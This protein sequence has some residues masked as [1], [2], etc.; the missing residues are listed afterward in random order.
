M[1]WGSSVKAAKF[2]KRGF[3]KSLESVSKHGGSGCGSIVLL[4][5]TGKYFVKA[6][7]YKQGFPDVSSQSVKQECPTRV[8]SESVK[9][10]CP[11]KCQAGV[12][13]QECPA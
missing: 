11:R 13:F 5:C 12:F 3:Y 1:I 2:H 10:E 8:P 6:L 7:Q 4:S 9:Q